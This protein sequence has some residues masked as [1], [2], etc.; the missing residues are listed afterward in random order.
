MN[1]FPGGVHARRRGP[2]EPLL[3]L[4]A[5]WVATTTFDYSSFAFSLF[6]LLVVDPTIPTAI[7]F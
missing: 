7:A 1:A 5:S 4:P 6:F 3:V 2:Q